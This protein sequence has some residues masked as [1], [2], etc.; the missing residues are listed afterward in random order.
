MSFGTKKI[1]KFLSLSLITSSFCLPW[2]S[3]VNAGLKGRIATMEDFRK[4][5][6]ELESIFETNN[7][8]YNEYFNM[9][10]NELKKNLSDMKFTSLQE[11]KTFFSMVK[12][13]R[14]L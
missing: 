2:F 7:E 6:S 10:Y 13:P 4:F 1:R 12:F 11:A 8:Y 9:E 14:P 3:K 5:T